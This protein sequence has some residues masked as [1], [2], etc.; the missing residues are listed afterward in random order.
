MS[1]A[2]KES[3]LCE[4]LIDYASK[5][6]WTAYPETAGWDILLVKDNVQ[7]GVEAKLSLNLKVVSQALG[8]EARRHKVGP[9]F[10]CV[11]TPSKKGGND[12]LNVLH[13]LKIWHFEYKP[14]YHGSLK[15]VPMCDISGIALLGDISKEPDYFKRKIDHYRWDPD[16]KEKLPE[17]VPQV[18]A[19]VPSP[20][21]LTPWKIKA[22]KFLAEVHKKGYATSKMAKAHGVDIRVFIDYPNHWLKFKEQ[23]GRL[24]HYELS[25]E[26]KRPDI[27]HP[28]VFKQIMETP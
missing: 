7:V 21:Q 27:V 10:R 18:A 28:E 19:G 3:E 6:G 16:K 4:K 17:F 24:H 1:T 23:V 22:L 12:G 20:I 2:M 13:T 8:I 14:R 5:L 15:R 25:M 9:G 26:K 11:L